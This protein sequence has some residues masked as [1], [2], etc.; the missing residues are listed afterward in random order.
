MYRHHFALGSA[1]PVPASPNASSPHTQ[2][3]DTDPLLVS[4]GSIRALATSF[5]VSDD[6]RN[7]ATA[8]RFASHIL[9][10]VARYFA[11]GAYAAGAPSVDF[12]TPEQ[13]I[14]WA[15][16]CIRQVYDGE[17]VR[18]VPSLPWDL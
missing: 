5:G 12:E 9:S 14:E 7:T 8:L 13:G 2:P 11:S 15:L 18:P 3:P 10:D 17:K 4:Y 16:S 6:E 1:L